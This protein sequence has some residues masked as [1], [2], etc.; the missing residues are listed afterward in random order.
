M[1]D[2]A[3]GEEVV[4]GEAVGFDGGG[5]EWQYE[6]VGGEWADAGSEWDEEPGSVDPYDPA[7]PDYLRDLVTDRMQEM[8]API[9]ADLEQRQYAAALEEAEGRA[10]DMLAEMI[11][12]EAYEALSDEE[13]GALRERAD[14]V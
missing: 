11:G 5:A 12:A 2:L 3:T 7:Y 14:A 13:Y 10:A 4:G 8:L 1:S 9:A 6:A